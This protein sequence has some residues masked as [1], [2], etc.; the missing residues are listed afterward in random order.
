MVDFSQA[1]YEAVIVSN[2]GVVTRDGVVMV[3]ENVMDRI[4]RVRRYKTVRQLA[5]YCE[6][7]GKFYP[8]ERA[9][10]HSLMKALL[11]HVSEHL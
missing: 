3:E 7:T 6:D 1:L 9:K 10:R 2:Y 5:L 8:A 11:R 4:R